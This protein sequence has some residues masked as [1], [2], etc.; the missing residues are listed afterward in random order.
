MPEEDD[1][2]VSHGS[3]FSLS[4]WSFHLTSS[5]TSSEIVSPAPVSVSAPISVT[6][7]VPVTD[8][9]MKF[10][11]IFVPSSNEE[12]W[13]SV[14]MTLQGS[15]TSFNFLTSLSSIPVPSTSATP[16]PSTSATPGLLASATL[17]PSISSTSG[18]SLSATPVPFTS[19][20]P[21]PLTSSTPVPLTST[22]PDPVP[23]LILN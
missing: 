17:L 9:S 5:N 11:V 16:V 4:P 14:Q 1:V 19:S 23:P 7:A 12:E 6:V 13:V 8:G 2:A 3:N 20:I 21:V 18:P 15:G 22:T 10:S